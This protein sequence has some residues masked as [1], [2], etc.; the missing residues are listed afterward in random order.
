MILADL[1][2]YTFTL[3]QL[4]ITIAKIY[5]VSTYVR[6]FNIQASFMLT[7]LSFFSWLFVFGS[8]A[9]YAKLD[10]E[11]AMFYAFIFR[12]VSFLLILNVFFTALE[13]LIFSAKSVTSKSRNRRKQ[14]E[15]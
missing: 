12:V 5:N 14:L 3:V 11:T 2:I 10:P 8:L 7:A 13:V 15:T 9:I 1:I 6:T 4:G